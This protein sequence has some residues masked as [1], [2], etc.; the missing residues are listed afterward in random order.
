M[1]Y[2]ISVVNQKGGVGKTTTSVNL[3][4][5]LAQLDK[6]VL[7]IDFDPQGHSGEHIGLNGR[8]D[9]N[10]TILEAVNG[11]LTLEQVVLPTYKKN[12]YIAPSN[13]RLG[14]YNQSAPE[15]KHFGL[16]DALKTEF[17]K[18]FDFVFIDCQPSLSLLTLN[19]LA[20]SDKVLLPVQ[21]EFL[22]LDGLTQLIMTFREIKSKLQP[23]L[24]VLGL[25]LTMFDKRNKLSMEI[26]K[27]LQQSFGA[28]LFDTVIPRSVR[29]AEAPSFGQSIFEYSPSTD[30]SR[31][32]KKLAD[33]IM[34]KLAF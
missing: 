7:L 32:Y 20:A 14:Q 29:F 16:R 26:K 18:Q 5:A 13:L 33:E 17:I 15:G 24:S 12:L 10:N 2:I 6:K 1:T 27:E 31:S 8:F 28:D 25:V 22:A 11:T 4:A 34:D 30:A 9:Q 21:S 19:A 23:S 3:S